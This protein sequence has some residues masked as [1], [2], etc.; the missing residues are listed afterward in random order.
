MQVHGKYELFLYHLIF[1]VFT[2]PQNYET[3]RWGLSGPSYT[4]EDIQI[5]YSK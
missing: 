1:L 5:G 4:S 2:M 3:Q